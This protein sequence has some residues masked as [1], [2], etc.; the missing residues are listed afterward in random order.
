MD[1]PLSQDA[2][3]AM[4]AAAALGDLGADVPPPAVTQ[5]VM[6]E[7]SGASAT[8][9]LQGPP[10][11]VVE[12]VLLDRLQGVEAPLDEQ[13]DIDILLDVPVSIAVE[14][15]QATITI[16]D[17][18]ELGKGTVLRLDR[19][20]GEPVDVLVNG[21]VLARGEVVVYDEDFGVRI[22]DV[23]SKADRV[24]SMGE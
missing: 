9:V 23:A 17:L 21:Q 6:A 11:P 3:D 1:E 22:T 14:L 18:I 4:L 19:R 12:S 24:R 7:L 5:P 16:R 2:L 15:G 8:S 13:A 10:E 20:A